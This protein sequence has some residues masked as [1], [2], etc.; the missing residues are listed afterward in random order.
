M[1]TREIPQAEWRRFFDDFSP[2]HAGWIVILEVLGADLGDQ[3]E[4]TR[5]PLVGISADGRDRASRVEIIVGG[6]PGHT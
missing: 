3:E 5:L 1:R 4:A 6:R 2:Q